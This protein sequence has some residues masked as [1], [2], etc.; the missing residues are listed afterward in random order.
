MSVAFKSPFVAEI[1]GSGF[2]KAPNEAFE[3]L[4][5]PRIKKIHHDRTWEDAVSMDDLR[6]MA[7]EKWDPPDAEELNCHARDV[8]LLVRKYLTEEDGSHGNASEC[9]T[10][11]E[12]TQRSAAS[13]IR[14]SDSASKDPVVQES[15]QRS[16]HT[17][18]TI[19]SSQYSGSTQGT[20]IRA[21]RELRTILVREDTSERVQRQENV[22]TYPTPCTS[23]GVSTTSK[24]S[25]DSNINIISPPSSKRRR[26]LTPLADAR[27]NR[28]LGS[29]DYDS[30]AKVIH[31]FAEEGLKVQV[32]T[33]SC[34]E[35]E[36]E[37]F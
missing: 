12:T 20:G 7:E 2:E 34:T 31:I 13:T 21:S 23:S 11:Q 8:A 28:N 33:G 29:F 24:R 32:H 15:Q 16:S 18:T 25:F 5:H 26:I 17:C 37:I 36:V 6:R 4:R 9:E 19:S 1:L 14:T 30:Q 35:E 10:T 22:T 27:G 3:M